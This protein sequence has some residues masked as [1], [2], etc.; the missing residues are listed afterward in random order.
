[1]NKRENIISIFFILIYLT[2]GLIGKILV[3]KILGVNEETLNCEFGIRQILIF[4]IVEF[5][6]IVDNI[7]LFVWIYIHARR[8]FDNPLFYSL[9]GLV[10]GLVGLVFYFSISLVNG[11]SFNK[12][13]I[14]RVGILMIVIVIISFLFGI[15][16]RIQ[17]QS[18]LTILIG[19][20]GLACI[21]EYNSKL[22]YTL[23]SVGLIAQFLVSIFIAIKFFSFMKEL[24]IKPFIWII[25]TFV[26]GIIPWIVVNILTLMN[27]E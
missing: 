12:L 4:S 17:G 26:L 21:I 14:D 11:K 6:L 9:I 23:G 16:Y 27:K 1:M 3:A 18:L 24:N 8:E 25:A 2:F 22:S 13:K 7:V 20:S 15:A 19:N 10:F 5:L